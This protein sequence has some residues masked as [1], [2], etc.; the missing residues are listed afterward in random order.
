MNNLERIICT[1]MVCGTV[2]TMFYMLQDDIS[3]IIQAISDKIKP[4][5]P[6]VEIITKEE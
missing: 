3:N 4:F 6:K 2:L 1:A 5:E